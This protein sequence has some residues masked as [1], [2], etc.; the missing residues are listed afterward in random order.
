MVILISAPK[1]S[2]SLRKTALGTVIT[3]QMSK[4]I[5]ELYIK[6]YGLKNVKVAI[7]A[8][9]SPVTAMFNYVD[10]NLND[11][12]VIFGVSTKGDDVKRFKNALKYYEDNEHINLLDPVE[13]AV[14]PFKDPSGKAVSAT[15][16]RDNLDKPDEVKKMLPDKL[17][18][19]DKDAVLKILADGPK[20]NEKI[21]EVEVAASKL[22]PIGEE[23]C[24]HF[25]VTDDLLRSA[26]ILAY[27]TN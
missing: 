8:E 1:S 26:K 16:I 17:S 13:T 20:E 19:A 22:S 7:S 11:V 21:E 25:D 24:M 3:P 14:E 15:D 4:K 18:N 12:N 27:N 6:R 9:P 5:W 23:E 2:K 10:N